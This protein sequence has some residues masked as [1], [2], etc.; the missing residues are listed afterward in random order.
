MNIIDVTAAVIFNDEGKVL[1]AKRKLGKSLENHWEFP[2]GKIERNETEIDCLKREML[3]EFWIKVEIKKFLTTSKHDYKSFVINLKAYNVKYISG[4]FQLRE[5]SEIKWI[6]ISE[7][8]KYM[9]AP[10]DIPIN[11]YLVQN[12]Y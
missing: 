9:F 2:G 6:K 11:E 5:H 8:S 1:I 7:H 10:A 4:D 12:G 3:E